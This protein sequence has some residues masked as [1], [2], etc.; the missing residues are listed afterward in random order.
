METIRP[1]QKLFLRCYVGCICSL[2]GLCSKQEI[3]IVKKQTPKHDASRYLFTHLAD[4]DGFKLS[5]L[6]HSTLSTLLTFCSTKIAKKGN[7]YPRLCSPNPIII[8]SPAKR[9][10]FGTSWRFPLKRRRGGFLSLVALGACC[11]CP[12]QCWVPRG[13][14]KG[15]RRRRMWR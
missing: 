15:S 10:L 7:A 1:S 3:D 12:R 6:L 14:R 8:T 11:C 2:F 4:H 5:N 9:R 13:Q